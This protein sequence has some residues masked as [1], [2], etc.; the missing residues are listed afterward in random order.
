MLQP[1]TNRSVNTRLCRHIRMPSL[2]NITETRTV[3]K[4]PQHLLH[5]YI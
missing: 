5:T 3:Q 4:K 1:T 2:I